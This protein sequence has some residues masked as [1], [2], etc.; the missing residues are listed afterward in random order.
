MGSLVLWLPGGF[1]QWEVLALE[2][3]VVVRKIKILI[4]MPTTMPPSFGL[5]C[6]S[7]QLLW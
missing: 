4:T 5:F 3:R 7:P 6:Q 1:G 2:Q